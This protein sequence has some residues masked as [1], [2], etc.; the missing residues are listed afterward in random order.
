VALRLH[1]HAM[2][3]T[4]G[5]RSLVT[6]FTPNLM[7]KKT[8][9][10]LSQEQRQAIEEAAAASDAYFENTQ[11]EIEARGIEAFKTAGVEVRNLTDQELTDWFTLARQTVWHRYSE[12]NALSRELMRSAIG[13]VH[14]RALPHEA[15]P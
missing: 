9:D 15:Q 6:C 1:E 4:F 2:L 8:W 14:T 10:R 3:G 11:I 7:S 12:T 5:G 13:V